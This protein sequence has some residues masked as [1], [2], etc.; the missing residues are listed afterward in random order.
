MASVDIKVLPL[1][2]EYDAQVVD[3]GDAPSTVIRTEDGWAVRMQWHIDGALA[4]A[5]GG[6]W[7]PQV[8][9]ESQGTGLEKVVTGTL[10]NY[11]SGA[12]S[13]IGSQPRASFATTIPFAPGDPGL[14]GRPDVPF[15][16]TAML[17]HIDPTNHP[18][19]L[20]AV[21][22]LGTVLFFDSSQL[23]P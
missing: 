16:V 4:H 2:G 5:L 7:R 10:I 9:L 6:R 15:Q 20:A 14:G 3:S 11:S 8:A 21:V 12:F 13:Y 23:A 19:P 1:T 18:G 17:T 22:D